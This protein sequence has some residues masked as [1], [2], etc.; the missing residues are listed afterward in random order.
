MTK[1][2]AHHY[3]QAL[4]QV[5]TE[6]EETQQE[7]ISKAAQWIAEAIAEER[8]GVIFGSGHS[9]MPA[10]DTFPRIGSYPGWLPIHELSTSTGLSENTILLSTA[11]FK[12]APAGRIAEVV[13]T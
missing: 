7:N 2:T 4:N 9:Y 10:S 3:L 1:I 11:E 5:L 12:R 13:D 8:F 6:L